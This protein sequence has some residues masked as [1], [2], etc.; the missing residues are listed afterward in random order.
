[1]KERQTVYLVRRHFGG[2]FSTWVYATKN[3]AWKYVAADLM[4]KL[5]TLPELAVVRQRIDAGGNA[6]AVWQEF[7]RLVETKRYV[8][9]LHRYHGYVF[10]QEEKLDYVVEQKQVQD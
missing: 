4:E 6:A 8:D 10:D 1:M 9:L 5:R 3:G 7:D 2:V